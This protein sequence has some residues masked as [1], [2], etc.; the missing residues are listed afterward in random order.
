VKARY[1]DA[2]MIILTAIVDPNAETSLDVDTLER[3][4]AEVG[5]EKHLKLGITIAERSR[6]R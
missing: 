5:R 1:T 4:V 3:V 2:G 6:P